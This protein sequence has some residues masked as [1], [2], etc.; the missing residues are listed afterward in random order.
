[1]VQPK[2]YYFCITNNEIVQNF[3]T[4]SQKNSHSCVPFKSSHSSV[5]LREQGLGTN[6]LVTKLPGNLVTNRCLGAERGSRERSLRCGYTCPC[7]P[8]FSYLRLYMVGCAGSS[9][10]PKRDFAHLLPRNIVGAYTDDQ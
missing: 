9:V 8:S 2:S 7:P 3:K 6:Q 10:T 5:P 4:Q 1:M